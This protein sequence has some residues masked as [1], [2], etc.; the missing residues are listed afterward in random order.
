MPKNFFE[1]MVRIKRE[2]NG[3]PLDAPLPSPSNFSKPK[4]VAKP[5]PRP[6]FVE[7]PRMEEVAPKKKSTESKYASMYDADGDGESDNNVSRSS[8]KGIWIV[9]AISVGFL[10]FALSYLF[11]GAKVIITPKS[12]DVVLQENLTAIKGGT[13]ENLSFDLVVLS[14]EE[15][16]SVV[17]GEEQDVFKRAKGRAVIYNSFSTASQNL[18]ID[19]RLEGSNGKIYKTETKITVPGKSKTGTPGSV[20]VGIYANEPGIEYNSGPLDF[21]IFGF[22]GT[23]K[24]EKF[25]ARSKGDITGGFRGKALSVSDA[26]KEA[27]LALLKT[28]LTEKLSKKANDQIPAGFI[29]FKDAGFLDTEEVMPITSNIAAGG[30]S[31]PITLK[32]TFYGVLF[33]EEK[34]TQKIAKNLVSG[35]KDEGVYI[36]NMRDVAFSLGVAEKDAVSL[37]DAKTIAFNLSGNAKIVWKVDTEQFMADIV[38]KPKKSFNQILANYPN[39]DSA[40]LSIRPIWK[41]SFP[42]KQ[43]SITVTTIE[44]L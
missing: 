44:P 26:D 14:G 13:D 1:D 18:D 33:D 42:E 4:I 16:K 40:T 17:G 37:K 29:L 21:K 5:R 6:E 30:G 11:A 36:P 27:A 2:K 31:V 41:M 7:E 43:E 34:L 39:I 32:G 24:Y 12:Q 10:L 19:T 9:A 8:K 20:E 3:I 38:G 22:K 28:T 25:Y 35:Y 23:P 15:T